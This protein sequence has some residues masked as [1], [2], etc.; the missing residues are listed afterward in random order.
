MVQLQLVVDEAAG[1]DVDLNTVTVGEVKSALDRLE[2][3]VQNVQSIGSGVD[4]TVTSDLKDAF[5]KLQDSIRDVPENDTLADARGDV[6]GA[7]AEFRTAWDDTVDALNC[8]TPP[9]TT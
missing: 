5:A 3:M 9:T 8:P 2:I 6:Q 4:E 1:A 7:R